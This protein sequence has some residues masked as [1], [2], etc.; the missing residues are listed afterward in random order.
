MTNSNP[1][2]YKEKRSF[3]GPINSKLNLNLNLNSIKFKF[4]LF[5]AH[6]NQ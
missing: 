2:K 3:V 1:I 4:E 6:D 5:K